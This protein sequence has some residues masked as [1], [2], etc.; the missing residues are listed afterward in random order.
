MKKQV[1]S[2]AL[3]G[4]LTLGAMAGCNKDKPAR[5]EPSGPI[6]VN[7][8]AN[9]GPSSKLK[10]YDGEWEPS[11]KVGLYM[12]QT[13]VPITTPGAVFNDGN[14][15]E[16]SIAEG[17]LSSSPALYYPIEGNVDFIAYYP[18]TSS[19]SSGYTIDVNVADQATVV[20]TLYSANV[21][22]Q[23]ATEDPVTLDFSYSLAKLVV[24][25]KGTLAA[26]LSQADLD[27]MS[28]SVNGLYT[29]A[30]LNLAT[31]LFTDD[32]VLQP[33]AL[34]KKAAATTSV[35]FEAL[36]LPAAA[37]DKTF[38]FMVAGTPYSYVVTESLLAATEYRFN[39]TLDISDVV[40]TVALLDAAILARDI[41]TDDFDVTPDEDWKPIT[42]LVV[43]GTVPPAGSFLVG[44]DFQLSVA[45][46]P[47]QTNESFEWKSSNPAVATVTANGF[48]TATVDAL[49]AGT[50][51]IYAESES[52]LV[53]SNQISVT[54][55]LYNDYSMSLNPTGWVQ[56]MAISDLGDGALSLT[57]QGTNPFIEAN[58]IGTTVSA[59]AV[60]KQIVFE[61]RNNKASHSLRFMWRFGGAEYG[62][63]GQQS[64]IIVPHSE[65]WTTIAIDITSPSNFIANFGASPDDRFRFDIIDGY[66]EADKMYADMGGVGDYPEG[67]GFAYCIGYQIDVR[68]LRLRVIY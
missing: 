17:V 56:E 18:H 42:G 36:V 22:D 12:M 49:S 2:Y 39:F 28:V 51:L 23:A 55:S 11:D 45:V 7:L 26:D 58:S 60:K 6:A 31:G 40:R 24:N 64:K 62:D 35:T 66:G 19:V 13:G 30:K 1:F 9:I 48:L 27:G 53:T 59:G 21:V 44:D 68:N 3:T 20:E 33:I 29:Q 61:Y 54:V 43:S 52:G 65:E 57:S 32:D 46:S 5:P 8:K 47:S 67:A 41:V 14:N 15:V 37:G 34:V 25:V 4:V 50:A 38:A 63:A 16:M 10:V